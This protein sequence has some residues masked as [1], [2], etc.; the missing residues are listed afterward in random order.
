MKRVALRKPKKS[1]DRSIERGA[2]VAAAF[3]LQALL[4]H[5]RHRMEA[6]ERLL[7]ALKRKEDLAQQRLQELHGFK[8][9]YQARLSGDRAV[10]MDIILLRDFYVFLAKLDNAIA[11]QNGEVTNAHTHWKVAHDNWLVLRQKVKAFETLADRHAKQEIQKQ[12][13]REQRIT[14]ETALRKH[15]NRNGETF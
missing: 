12:E 1:P 9:E 11:H 10:V 4:D 6:A 15:A 7:R 5:S 3:P 2:E 14:D 8:S 13:K